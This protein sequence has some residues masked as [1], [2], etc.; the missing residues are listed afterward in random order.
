[1]DIPMMAN[2]RNAFWDQLWDGSDQVTVTIRNL[3]D[4]FKSLQ[5]GYYGPNPPAVAGAPSF[6]DHYV[7]EYGYDAW[8]AR[9]KV[10]ANNAN[11]E[12]REVFIMKLRKD[13][14]SE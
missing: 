8:D 3:K 1:M 12:S 10:V 7:K 5:Q 14:S 9:Q 2:F 4:G 13:L 6:R 11:V